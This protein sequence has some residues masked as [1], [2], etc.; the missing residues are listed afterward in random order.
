M[1][2]GCCTVAATSKAEAQTVD[3]L[4]SSLSR[5]SVALLVG[6]IVLDL[7]AARRHGFLHSLEARAE[8]PPADRVRC[9]PAISRT[10]LPQDT[11]EARVEFTFTR[12]VLRVFASMR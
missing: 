10:K 9:R 8:G 5:A 3:L 1:Y 7:R 4:P 11:G 6:N 12:V 2:S